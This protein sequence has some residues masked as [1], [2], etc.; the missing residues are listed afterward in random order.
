MI[1]KFLSAFL[2]IL[3]IVLVLVFF[4]VNLYIGVGYCCI[5]NQVMKPLREARAIARQTI[6]DVLTK[7]SSTDMDIASEW[8]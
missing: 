6:R 7:R 2:V 5:R 4:V 8:V 3:V 1:T